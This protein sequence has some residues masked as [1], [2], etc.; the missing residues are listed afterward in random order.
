MSTAWHLNK[1]N[2]E[3]QK[4]QW[5]PHPPSNAGADPGFFLG[6]GALI[7]CSTLTP[8]NHIV[9]FFFEKDQLY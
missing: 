4:Y 2:I 7:S 8:I 6:G 1:H 3:E 9:L 5:A